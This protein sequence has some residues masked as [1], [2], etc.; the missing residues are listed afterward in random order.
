VRAGVRVSA[1]GAR[2]GGHRSNFFFVLDFPTLTNG[3]RPLTRQPEIIASAVPAGIVEL[4]MMTS[5]PF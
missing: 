4:A 3:Q 2:A 1:R 5:G